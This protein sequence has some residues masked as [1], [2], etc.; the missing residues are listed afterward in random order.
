MTAATCLPGLGVPVWACLTH[1]PHQLLFL[2][3]NP[4]LQSNPQQGE[5]HN[6]LRCEILK[7]FG[8]HNWNIV[9]P[10]NVSQLI[11]TGCSLGIGPEWVGSGGW[12]SGIFVTTPVLG[13]VYLVFQT[14]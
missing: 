3:L 4:P 7:S 12:E 8:K 6:P 9:L 10:V 5:E 1:P 2:A 13:V 14:N 11:I